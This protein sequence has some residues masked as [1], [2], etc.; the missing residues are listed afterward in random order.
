MKRLPE[1]K[2]KGTVTALTAATVLS[3]CLCAC[4]GGGDGGSSNPLGNPSTVS[5]PVNTGGQKLSF[6]YF[7]RCINPILLA[8]LPALQGGGFTNSCAGAGCHDTVTGAGGALRVV[9]GALPVDL[10]DPAN[11]PAVIRNS[12]MYK[13]YYSAQGAV[14]VGSPT[15]SRLLAKPMLLVLHGGG[16]IF[17]SLSDANAARIAYWINNPMPRGQDEFSSAAS[18]LFSPP[19][20]QTGNC[21]PP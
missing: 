17:A 10:S 9:P 18:S 1:V 2:R 7:Q 4:G 13:N 15:Q 12:D 16:Q 21:N 3:A 6:A 20:P 5:N 11:T 14:V 19:D 8:Q